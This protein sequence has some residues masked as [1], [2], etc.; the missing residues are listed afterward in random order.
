MVYLNKKCKISKKPASLTTGHCLLLL[1]YHYEHP[2]PTHFLES[3]QLNEFASK[4]HQV[5]ALIHQFEE[6]VLSRIQI[7]DGFTKDLF[8]DMQQKWKLYHESQFQRVKNY[9]SGVYTYSQI[10]KFTDIDAKSQY[11]QTESITFYH[12]SNI[13]VRLRQYCMAKLL[14]IF[15]DWKAFFT[16]LQDI[17]DYFLRLYQE[18]NGQSSS[19]NDKNTSEYQ[20]ENENKSEKEDTKENALPVMD[21]YRRSY[22]QLITDITEATVSHSYAQTYVSSNEED[23]SPIAYCITSCE[24]AIKLQS[25]HSPLDP[26]LSLESSQNISDIFK[27]NLLECKEFFLL[28]Y[29]FSIVSCTFISYIFDPKWEVTSFS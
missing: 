1:T 16:A 13:N 6:D 22:V 18:I 5:V 3:L 14:G 8:D 2:D 25:K 19:T 11:Y 23:F 27:S 29:T 12:H 21:L 10:E 20:N 15:D 4:L 24:E 26:C 17:G 9:F 7:N 28:S